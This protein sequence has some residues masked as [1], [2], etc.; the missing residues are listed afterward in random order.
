MSTPLTVSA[1]EK[2]R[3]AAKLQARAEKIP[4]SA[5]LD[6]VARQEGHADWQAVRRAAPAAASIP[7]G[8]LPVDP[9]LPR[10]F[11]DT[12]NEERSAAE[13]NAWWLR[14]F[15]L[16]R[17]DG[18]LDVRCLDGGAW[19]RATYYGTAPNLAEA[20]AIA[21][22]GLARWQAMRDT[23]IVFMFGP[24]AILLVLEP[25]RPGM[26]RPVLHAAAG[27]KDAAQFLADWK[28]L[29]A[30]QP[31]AAALA[32]AGARA[33]SAR[34]PTIDAA[35]AAARRAQPDGLAYA[36]G[37]PIGADGDYLGALRDVGLLLII[38]RLP[39]PG[40]SAVSFSGAELASYFSS[41]GLGESPTSAE[42]LER[43]LR[44]VTVRGDPLFA[45]ATRTSTAGLDLW[46]VR[47]GSRLWPSRGGRQSAAARR[48]AK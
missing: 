7:A 34:V 33:R 15:A 27:Q 18:S 17:P 10:H 28:H 36:D 23:P 13:L 39:E 25:N 20:R 32:I 40:G 2:M 44:G 19:D 8:D 4:Y 46:T 38:V 48:D 6:A 30:A 16:T 35:E 11:D 45:E 42:D 41:Y 43:L 3:R 47:L 31:S 21:Q 24:G 1:I 9:V 14:P 22:G 29:M 37:R 5:A 26:A 12:P